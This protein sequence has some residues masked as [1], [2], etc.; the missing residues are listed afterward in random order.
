MLFIGFAGLAVM[1]LLN[2]NIHFL[3]PAQEETNVTKFIQQH[4]ILVVS[5]LY[6]SVVILKVVVFTNMGNITTN[7]P[8]S[9]Y[10]RLPTY[11]ITQWNE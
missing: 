3:N 5:Y 6:N 2:T 9:I 8:N 11:P 4:C 10:I 7:T 1:H